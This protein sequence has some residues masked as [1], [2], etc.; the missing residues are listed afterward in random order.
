MVKKRPGV[1]VPVHRTGKVPRFAEPN[2]AGTPFCWRVSDI[3]WDGPLGWSQ[4]TCE[5]LL[6]EVVP[7]LHDLESMKWGEVEGKTGSHFV[8][9]TNIAPGAQERLVKIRRDEQAQLFSLRVTGRMRLWGIRD[10][11]ILRLLWWDPNHEVCPS[12][13]TDN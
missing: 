3:D 5:E 11:A 13:R 4:A 1:G 9:V 2:V 8:E 7:R 12:H 10:I 6:K